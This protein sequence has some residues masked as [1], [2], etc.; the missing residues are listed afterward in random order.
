MGTRTPS[1]RPTC[2]WARSEDLL[3]NLVIVFFGVRTISFAFLRQ[4]C[5]R[6]GAIQAQ[7]RLPTASSVLPLCGVTPCRHG[8]AREVFHPYERQ[9]PA[10]PRRAAVVCAHFAALPGERHGSAPQL[11]LMQVQAS[12][13]DL[14]RYRIITPQ[15]RSS[16]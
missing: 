16:A 7:E 9:R 8:S 1:S 14:F 11:E 3:A 2:S 13:Q 4:C 10:E 6:K 12:H 5:Q 15:A